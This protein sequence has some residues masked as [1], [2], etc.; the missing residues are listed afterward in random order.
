MDDFTPIAQGQDDFQQVLPG[1]QPSMASRLWHGA[2]TQDLKGQNDP[3]ALLARLGQTANK[4]N[5]QLMSSAA[6]KMGQIGVNPYVAA[7]L[8][9]PYAALSEFLMPQ[10]R[11]GAGLTA[12][13]AVAKAYRGTK[14]LLA[15]E[16]TALGSLP[17]GSEVSPSPGGA[18]LQTPS[19]GP[20]NPG[21]LG[22]SITPEVANV[23][24]QAQN[25]IQQEA[26]K[27]GMEPNSDFIKKLA[28][29]FHKDAN[30]KTGEMLSAMNEAKKAG[31]LDDFIK[32]STQ[33]PSYV[34]G[35]ESAD[36]LNVLSQAFPQE[37]STVPHDPIQSAKLLEDFNKPP[38]A[39]Y[40]GTMGDEVE[41]TPLFN[42]MKEGHPSYKST[43]SAE[44]LKQQ[45]LKVPYYPGA[46]T[47]TDAAIKA[48]PKNP[49]GQ[50]AQLI[51]AR[52]GRGKITPEIA[53]YAI[54][55]PTVLDNAPSIKEATD[56]YAK[57][58]GGLKG[59][60]ASIAE[61]LNKTVI[62]PGDYDAAIDRAGRLLNGTP[63]E[64]DGATKLKP[65]DALEGLQ[66]I[67]QA[68]RDKMYTSAMHPDQVKNIMHVKEGL[69]DFLQ[70]NGRPQLRAAGQQ[71]FEAHVKDAFSNWLPKNKFGSPDALRTMAGM[72]QM[73]SAGGALAA[74]VATG[75]PIGGA[76]AA[77]GI[78]L[79][80]AMTSPRVMGQAIRELAA[81]KNPAIW[82]KAG[83][84]GVGA[85]NALSNQGG[86]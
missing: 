77:G 19:S 67:N 47:T 11:L 54:D 16:E 44:T 42:V 58:A 70:N 10:N 85:S 69:L 73:A 35:K 12:L 36:K 74:G 82:Q 5:Q 71:L 52:A 49:P 7:A 65:Q 14:A 79:N 25:I 1:Q 68:L 34:A 86:Q 45:G 3:L 30:E 15:G 75:H 51:T 32:N 4:G 38:D 23:K 59:K 63:I 24:T 26:Q 41:K 64:S 31:T 8:T 55:H 83:V 37:I 43:V 39:K 84:A 80:A 48:A 17:S 62:R 76:L 72:G 20:T 29:Y 27:R 21:S 57:A 66:S 50:F 53:Q 56:E 46:E 6:E 78:G 9:T 81:I 2:T 13:P 18:S 60:A 40:I 28:T 33:H 22:A 61:R